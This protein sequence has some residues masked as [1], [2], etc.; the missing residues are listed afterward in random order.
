MSFRETYLDH[1]QL[2]AQVRAWATD[3]PDLVRVESIAK[4][5][6][7]RDVWLIKIG[8]DPDRVRPTAWIDGN[9]HASE[10]CGSS[11]ALAIAEDVLNLHRGEALEGLSAPV[12]DALREV[13]FY[14]CPRIS[15]DGAEAVLKTGRYVRSV[16]RDHRP[17]KGHARWVGQDIDGDGR[18]MLMRIEDPT[19]EF[20]DCQEVQGMLLPR[21]VDDRGPFFKVYPEGVIEGF[22]GHTVPDPHFLSDNDTDLNRNFPW[23]WAPEPDQIG[24]GAYPGSTPESR[25]LIELATRTPQLFFWLNYHTFGGVFIRPLGGA[26][27]AKMDRDDLALYR[28]IGAWAESMTGYP[29]V[30]GYEEFLYE[31]DKPLHGDLSD[32]AYHARGCVSYVVELWDL[33]KRIGAKRPKKFVDH[34]THLTRDDLIAL[35]RFDKVQNG[36]SA[37][38][39]WRSV[40]H[41]QLGP[42][43]VGG[44]DPTIGLSNPPYSMLAEVCAQHSLHALHVASLAPRI[45]LS[46]KVETLNQGLRRVLVT[47]ENIGYLPTYVLSSAKKLSFNE[48]L[49]ADAE[50]LGCE[51]VHPEEHHKE[52]GHL[53]GWGRGL[54]DGTSAI[55]Y[56]RSRGN[57]S[58][59][60]VSW[61]VSGQGSLRVK[62]SSCRMG[63]RSIVVEL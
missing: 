6:E 16:P 4:S 14:V 54:F 13:L 48:P 47:V 59:S 46:Q 62:V 63:E 21:T 34:Y 30:S 9:L 40:D 29:T 36:N 38:R 32:F 33:F 44:L 15:P 28:Q 42:V 19:G 18:Q 31:P 17:N 25:A 20:V 58:T 51:L 49:W 27:D 5:E 57:V 39:P 2:T 24:A 53:A 37:L 50:P 11:A 7:G 60:T 55:Y 1:E 3:H 10:L 45:R 12:Q 23:S 61:L 26:P 56:M 52:V 8:P 43:E 22:D 41:P 35:G